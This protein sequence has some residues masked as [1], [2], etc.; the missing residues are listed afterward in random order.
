MSY[1]AARG[2]RGHV[3]RRSIPLIAAQPR[4][5]TVRCK[6]LSSS[7]LPCYPSPSS[8]VVRPVVLQD[9]PKHPFPAQLPLNNSSR[10]LSPL[11][12]ALTQ[13][14]ILRHLKSF[15]MNTYTKTGGRAPLQASQFVNSLR[16]ATTPQPD[17]SATVTS[18]ANPSLS[19]NCG[20]VPSP[21]G[22]GGG[23]SFQTN[24]FRLLVPFLAPLPS[25]FNFRPSTSF[26]RSPR[27]CGIRLLSVPY[28]PR[29]ALSHSPFTSQT[30][31][32]SRPLAH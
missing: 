14:L 2:A 7:P 12:S 24:H 3:S 27:L 4:F 32:E 21:I 25:T 31:Y 29:P 6:V 23:T 10:S 16:P 15:R 22:V 26:R 30:P 17:I 9:P 5:S 8:M 28:G 18:L 11:E 1:D 13:V 19:I 20:H